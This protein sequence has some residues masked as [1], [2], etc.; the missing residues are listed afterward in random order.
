MPADIIEELKKLQDFVHPFSFSEVKELIEAEFDDELEN[1][2][3]EFD[4]EPL[5]AASISQFHRAMLFSGKQ[6]AVKVQRPFIGVS[7]SF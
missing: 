5:A 4:I 1:I 3:K 2:Y 7:Q 6:V